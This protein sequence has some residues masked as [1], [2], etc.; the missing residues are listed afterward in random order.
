MYFVALINFCLKMDPFFYNKFSQMPDEELLEML[1]QASKYR[2]VALENVIYVLKERH[3]EQ[4]FHMPE[5]T[6]VA[7]PVFEKDSFDDFFGNFSTHFKTFFQHYSLK[8][9]LSTVS[10]AFL[11]IAVWKTLFYLE[12]YSWLSET[13]IFFLATVLFLCSMSLNHIFYK[14]ENGFRNRLLG[15]LFQD[16]TLLGSTIVASLLVQS[17]FYSYHLEFTFGMI[18]G[19]ML[20]I[21]FLELILTLINRFFKV[22]SWEIW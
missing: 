11:F 17:F 22:F 13:A 9:I 20:I 15:R 7:E 3:P 10:L 1:E 6:E 5:R 19:L 14:K 2:P 12:I 16:F 18:I 21:I 8:E 4:E